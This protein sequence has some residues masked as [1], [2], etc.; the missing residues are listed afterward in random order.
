M[1]ARCVPPFQPELP[2]G[3]TFVIGAG[4]AAAAMAQT[5][6]M[7][8]RGRIDAGLVVIRYGHGLPLKTIEV[9]EAR[10]PLPDT[11]GLLA[12]GRILAMART[13]DPNDLLL[14]L[15]SAG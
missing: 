9:V 3:R 15:I 6:E 7:H 1:P 4:K 13:L 14:C 10:H 8:H 12:A 2:A 11:N 5:V